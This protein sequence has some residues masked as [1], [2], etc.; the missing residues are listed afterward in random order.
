MS[1]SPLFK[2]REQKKKIVQN[3]RTF[4]VLTFFEPLVYYSTPRSSTYAQHIVFLYNWTLSDS[5]L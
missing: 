5:G 2:I 1:S 4:T 3:F